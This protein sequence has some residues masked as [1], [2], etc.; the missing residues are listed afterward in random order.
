MQLL[1][2][3]GPYSRNWK[4]EDPDSSSHSNTIALKGVQAAEGRTGHKRSD[5]HRAPLNRGRPAPR[6][7]PPTPSHWLTPLFILAYLTEPLSIWSLIGLSG[8]SLGDRL[9][10]APLGPAGKTGA[11]LLWRRG[12]LLQPLFSDAPWLRGTAGPGPR[13]AGPGPHD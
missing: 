3:S 1:T 12:A 9:S 13:M 8:F 2:N 6:V 4:R 5:R 7:P 10:I 11:R